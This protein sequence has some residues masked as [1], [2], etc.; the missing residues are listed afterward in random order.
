MTIS[1]GILGGTFD[2]IHKQHIYIAEQA[3]KYFNLAAVHLVLAKQSPF[4]TVSKVS[5][6]D[7]FHMLQLAVQHLPKLVADQREA[8]QNQLSY[9]IDTLLSFRQQFPTARLA[10]IIGMDALQ[11]LPQ[12][13]QADF[14]QELTHFIVAPRIGFEPPSWVTFADPA[15]LTTTPAGLFFLLPCIADNTAATEIRSY[16]HS[17]RDN[18][19]LPSLLD[20][21]VLTYIKQHNLYE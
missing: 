19:R 3:Q 13:H 21:A 8:A 7:R 6:Q 2:P 4:K 1:I 11:T 5:Y 10:F 17:H 9:T 16:L 20:P 12:W 18:A 14:L 15:Q